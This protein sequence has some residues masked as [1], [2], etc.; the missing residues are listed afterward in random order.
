MWGKK[1]NWK[2]TVLQTLCEILQIFYK[3]SQ[4]SLQNLKKKSDEKVIPFPFDFSPTSCP[5][6]NKIWPQVSSRALY[7]LDYRAVLHTE[8]LPGQH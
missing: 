1:K 6:K 2:V 8:I 3:I 7:N 5:F 4:S